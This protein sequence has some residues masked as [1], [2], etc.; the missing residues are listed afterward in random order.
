AGAGARQVRDQALQD[1]EEKGVEVDVETAPEV[2]VDAV[3]HGVEEGG[4]EDAVAADEGE[5]G[6]ALPA[7]SDGHFA[8]GTADAFAEGGV[9][10]EEADGEQVEA[11]IEGGAG[12]DVGVLEEVGG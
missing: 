7:E 11:R 6:G 9:F 12:G 2:V 4:G 5:V 1:V 8:V 3:D 10:D